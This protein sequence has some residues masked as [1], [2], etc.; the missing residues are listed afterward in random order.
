M[1]TANLYNF[2][3]NVFFFV[4]IYYVLKYVVR[5][6]FPILVKKA[7]HHA[8]ENMRQK[9]GQYQNTSQSQDDF[10][11]RD[12]EVSYDSSQATKSR[13]T[14]KVGEYIDYEEIE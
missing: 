7:V 14:K 6:L 9:F 3:R 4:M 1:E 2:L 8:E 13:E 11:K 5:L 12:G 10:K